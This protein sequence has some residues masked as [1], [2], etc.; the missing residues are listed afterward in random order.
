MIACRSAAIPLPCS[1]F[2]SGLGLGLLHL[3]DLLRLAARLRRN[4]RALAALMSFMASLTLES[5]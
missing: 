4:L 2:D 5:G 1:A 3:Q